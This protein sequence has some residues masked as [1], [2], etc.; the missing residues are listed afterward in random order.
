MPTWCRDVSVLILTNRRKKTLFWPV[1]GRGDRA[2]A[3]PV[4]GGESFATTDIEIDSQPG[5]RAALKA[6][7]DAGI[8]VEAVGIELI[9]H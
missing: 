8:L 3:M 4:A 2:M 1:A 6:L 7:I 5:L 9:R